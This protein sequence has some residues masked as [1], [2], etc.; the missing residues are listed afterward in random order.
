MKH[1]VI[2]LLCLVALATIHIQAQENDYGIIKKTDKSITFTVD[3]NLPLPENKKTIKTDSFLK[4]PSIPPLHPKNKKT[5]KAD[6]FQNLPSIPPLH[7]KNKKTIVSSFKKDSLQNIGQDVLFRC[8]VKAYAEHK[9]LVLSP[10]MIWLDIC[11]VFGHYISTNAEIMRDKFVNHDG[12]VSLVVNTEKELLYEN[13]DWPKIIEGF[14]EQIDRNM[15]HFL[16]QTT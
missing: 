8:M 6:S 7:P 4:L 2:I 11:Q 5:A 16:T 1:V 10:D 9:P 12:K 14:I 13:A 15:W 3:E